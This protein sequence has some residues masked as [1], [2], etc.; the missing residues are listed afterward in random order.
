MSSTDAGTPPTAGNGRPDEPTPRRGLR[1]RPLGRVLLLVIVLAVALFVA[2]TC[3]RTDKNVSQEEA[4]ELATEAASFQPCT[5]TGCVQIR[6]IQRGIPVVGYWGVVLSEELDENGQP[7]RIESF[8]VN[9]TTG[10]VSRP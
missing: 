5:Q 2:R 4:I 1:D 3:G 8:I 9:V 6:Y 10:D 7:T